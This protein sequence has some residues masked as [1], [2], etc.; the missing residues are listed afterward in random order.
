MMSFFVTLL[1][2]SFPSGV[3]LP[4]TAGAFTA[5]VPGTTTGFGVAT[6]AAW[7]TGGGFGTATVMG[8]G[9]FAA[10]AAPQEFRQSL[11]DPGVVGTF[12]VSAF[13]AGGTGGSAGLSGVGVS[14]FVRLPTIGFFGGRTTSLMGAVARRLGRLDRRR[15]GFLSSRSRRY[16]RH[17]SDWSRH[18]DRCLN[19]WSRRQGGAGGI[20][21][22]GG[23]TGVGF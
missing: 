23:G 19:G 10:S 18:W 2:G 8:T 22:A 16:T 14:R 6:L 13:A 12:T 7:M 9:G 3:A 17:R 1:A 21:A 5:G 15:D 4:G 11:G 20:G